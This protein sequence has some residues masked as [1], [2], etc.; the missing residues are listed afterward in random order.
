[1]SSQSLE[2]RLHEQ[3][4]WT[5]ALIGA[6]LSKPIQEGEAP[7][8]TGSALLT[9]GETKEDV[10]EFLKNDIYAKIGVWDMSKVQIIP[11]R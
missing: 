4:P 11:V 10:L 8:M 2:G 7:D 1:L 9:V 3:A 5:N 6:L